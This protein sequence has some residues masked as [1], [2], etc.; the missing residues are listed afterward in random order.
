[1]TAAQPGR[2]MAQAA[3]HP[4]TMCGKADVALV[5]AIAAERP[6]ARV[7]EFGPWLGRLTALF[8]GAASV[9]V[10]DTFEW[11]RDHARRVDAGPAPGASFRPLF[12]ANVARHLPALTI[13]EA[14]FAEFDPDGKVFDLVVIDGPKSADALLDCLAPIAHALSPEA[15]LIIVGGANP[16]FY[17]LRAA[18]ARLVSAGFFEHVAIPGHDKAK[19]ALLRR[20][21]APLDATSLRRALV[22]ADPDP[23]ADLSAEDR[24]AVILDLAERGRWQGAY[25]Q[26]SVMVP[27]LD[28]ID[29][30]H[31]A[32]MALKPG[33][34]DTERLGNLAHV[35]ALHHEPPADGG[36][37]KGFSEQPHLAV[38][39]FW[40]N[41]DPA[42]RGASFIPEAI[43]RA[44]QLGY[45]RWPEDIADYVSGRRVLDVGCGQGLHGLGFL[46]A[47]AHR[48]VGIDQI[49]QHDRDVVRDLRA[50]ADVAFGWTPADLSAAIAPLE[51]VRAGIEEFETDERFDLVVLRH[52]TEHLRDFAGSFDRI[53][54][55]VSE[56]GRILILHGNYYAWNGHRMPPR[57]PAQFDPSDPEQ[58]RLVDWGHV[59]AEFPTDH[60]VSR[61]LNRRRIGELRS[62]LE[63]RFRIETWVERPSSPDQGHGRLTD[64][65]LARYPDFE[66]RDFETQEVFIVA[67]KS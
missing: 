48:Y 61:K 50:R 18:V 10:V 38:A 36:D 43:S 1:M 34:F 49:L 16:K 47:G 3:I 13:H 8:T 21:G 24:I 37:A 63:D 20:K 11:T 51:L 30:W 17:R 22:E 25:A 66:R 6:A 31:Q 42:W 62:A 14:P 12:E 19:A 32:E 57:S 65:I 58:C 56:G 39:A 54:S 46:A 33:T 2:L 52:V 40:R 44:Q 4:P 5:A 26:L 59:R 41:A 9:D 35:F 67:T 53:A 7:L 29:I 23:A 27:S 15:E 64:D 55:I 60:Y 28:S 45:M